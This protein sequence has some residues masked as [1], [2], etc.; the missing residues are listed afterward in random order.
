MLLD[1]PA[2]DYNDMRGYASVY[3]RRKERQIE[4]AQLP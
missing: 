4:N 1:L 2:S 3:N